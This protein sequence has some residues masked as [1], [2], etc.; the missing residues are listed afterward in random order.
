MVS[1][2]IEAYRQNDETTEWDEK[3][4]CRLNQG[5]NREQRA[6]FQN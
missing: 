3:R 6:S 2:K 4:D 1:V 5:T